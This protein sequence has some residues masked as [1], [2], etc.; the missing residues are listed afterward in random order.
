MNAWQLST[1]QLH[2]AEGVPGFHWL[3]PCVLR[4]DW[5]MG[6]KQHLLGWVGGQGHHWAGSR[7]D[8]RKLRGEWGSDP[9][10]KHH[11]PDLQRTTKS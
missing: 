9:R 10:L 7:V 6:W 5:A 8:P 11:L 3:L 2:V 4:E 1:C